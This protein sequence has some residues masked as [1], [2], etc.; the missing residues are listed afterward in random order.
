MAEEE[1]SGGEEGCGQNLRSRRLR[2]SHRCCCGLHCWHCLTHE[3]AC[4]LPGHPGNSSASVTK[5]L[6]L[7]G[8][9]H[10]FNALHKTKQN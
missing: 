9:K 7:N 2:W 1:H 5:Q 3:A 4:S 10:I 8:T 6:G